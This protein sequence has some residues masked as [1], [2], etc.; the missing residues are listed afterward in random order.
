M[1][2]AL[3]ILVLLVV[4]AV[5]AYLHVA[6]Q[7]Y[8]PVAKFASSDGFTF[9]VVQD[10]VPQRRACDEAN[11]RLL[12]PLKEQCKDCKVAHARCERELK[13]LE[14]ELLLGQPVAYYQ[15]TT[16]KLRMAIEGPGERLKDVCEDIA[17][18]MVRAGMASA[19]CVFP[20]RK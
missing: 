13:G 2:E 9:S 16:P 14:L 19:A 17:V 1:K 6:G 15:I 20:Q 10:A 12:A 8:H 5:F 18:S 3:V 4:G 7:S 11:D